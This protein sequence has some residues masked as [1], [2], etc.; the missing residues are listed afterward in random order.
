MRRNR[1]L[2]FATGLFVLAIVLSLLIA[3]HREPAYRGR[4]LSAWLTLAARHNYQDL[5]TE[6]AIQAMGTDALPCLVK[7][8]RTRDT[9]VRQAFMEWQ[10]SQRWAP[11]NVD[12]QRELQEQG[13]Y[14]FR[15]LKDKARP[16]VDQL[17]PLLKSSDAY[18]RASAAF[19]L[20]LIGPSATNAA[21]AVIRYLQAIQARSLAGKIDPVENLC[22]AVALAE[23][24]A[25]ARPAIPDLLKLANDSKPE[26]RFAASAALIRIREVPLQPLLDVLGETGNA[27]NWYRA[28][29]VLG[30]LSTNAAPAI[31]SLFPALTNQDYRIRRETIR[32]LGK[33]HSRPEQTLPVLVP[34]LA[35]TDSWTRSESLGAIR[36]FGPIA[37]QPFVIQEITKTLADQDAYVRTQATNTLRAIDPRSAAKL[38]PAGN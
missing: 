14:G 35:S 34:Y 7:L 33:I 29:G 4:K 2:L 20:S 8:V 32:V 15:V 27:T 21:S 28:T 18:V 5:A 3:T 38:N 31:P 17:T 12:S 26:V 22:A 24:G 37:N 16:A 36:A 30:F 10:Q 25:A 6:E 1:I 9:L 11:I 13:I 19:A 23:M